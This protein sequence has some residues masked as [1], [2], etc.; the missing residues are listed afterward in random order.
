MGIEIDFLPVGEK[1]KSGDAI[2]IRFGNLHGSRAEQTVLTVD[3]GTADSG[4]ALVEHVKQ[5]YGTSTVDIAILSHPDNDHA[6]G[7]RAILE[8]LT[9]RTVLMHRPWLHSDAIH[10]AFD[11]GRVT[12]DS[13]AQRIRENLAV[14]HE[15]ETI[16]TQ[17]GVPIIEPFEGVTL[18]QGI[19]R[20]LGP[21][22]NFYRE[23]LARYDFMPTAKSLPTLASFAERA[24][25]WLAET[26]DAELLREPDSEATSAEN[27]SSVVF[28]ITL[29]NRHYLFTGDSG[30]PALSR[31][32]DYAAT[33]AVEW[34]NI[35]FFQVPH[36]GSKR[37]IGP[38]VLNRLFGLPTSQIIVPSRSA[39]IS[40]AA[41]GEPKHPSK[42]VINALI[43][44]GVKPFV[45]AGAG[46]WHYVNA[47]NRAGWGPVE[48]L[49]F[50]ARVEDE[51]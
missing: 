50:F 24:V 23:L 33:M 16:A 18:N 9:V 13:I 49:A 42:R 47:P 5:Y 40:A 32:L 17:K 36:H 12:P 28:L 14:A 7:M 15:I 29:E 21:N 34:R 37:N 48:A 10:H 11:D 2:A 45:T 22:E 43:R 26:W 30:V 35:Q 44:R 4:D 1:G 3:G 19:I 27:N 25:N 38:S 8:G 46:K 31:S 51:E 20:V 39:F 41:E 6:S